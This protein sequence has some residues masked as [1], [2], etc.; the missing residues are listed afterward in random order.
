MLSKKWIA[1]PCLYGLGAGLYGGIEILWRGSTH[2][3]ML[4]TGGACLSGLYGVNHLLQGRNLFAKCGVGCAL[5]TGTEFG[6]GCLVNRLLHWNVWSYASQPL[7][8]LG[9]ICPLFSFFWF[10]L[11][12]PAFFLCE[13]VRRLFE[14]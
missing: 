8:L 13:G 4:L 14:P 6:V 12:I 2:W 3:T 11:C 1:Y 5:I 9:Q 10:L 7:N